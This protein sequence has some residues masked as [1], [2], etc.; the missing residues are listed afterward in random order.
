MDAIRTT[1]NQ[2]C[3]GL[4]TDAVAHIDRLLSNKLLNPGLKALFKLRG[5]SD[6]DFAS[7]LSEP[8]GS[9]QGGNWD[10]EVGS[11]YWGRFCDALGA[12]K[13]NSK[14]PIIRSRAVV[15]NYAKWIKEVS[16]PL[17][18]LGNYEC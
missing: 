10:P 6:A 4:L 16:L 1:S 14:F 15:L 9:V 18:L 11:D 5:L 3:T 7:V 2:T 17:R 12:G 13:A 8:L